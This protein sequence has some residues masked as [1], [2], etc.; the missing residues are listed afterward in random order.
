MGRYIP[1][2][3]HAGDYRSP[4]CSMQRT[5]YHLLDGEGLEITCFRLK[6]HLLDTQHHWGEQVHYFSTPVNSTVPQWQYFITPSQYTNANLH[7][8]RIPSDHCSHPDWLQ[9]A[10]C[11]KHRGCHGKSSHLRWLAKCSKFLVGQKITAGWQTLRAQRDSIRSQTFHSK[12]TAYDITKYP[13]FLT[14]YEIVCPFKRK[15]VNSRGTAYH[16]L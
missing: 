13:T 16:I 9:L 12:G 15:F 1:C 6:L 4:V 11:L 2:M 5:V 7:Y 3:Q 8:F 14:K 10:V